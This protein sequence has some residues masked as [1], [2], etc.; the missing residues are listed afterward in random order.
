MDILAE[1]FHFKSEYYTA[2]NWLIVY[3][4]FYTK[5]TKIQYIYYFK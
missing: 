3:K 4:Y 5:R 1:V 2:I